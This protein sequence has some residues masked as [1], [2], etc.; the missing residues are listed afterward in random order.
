[1]AEVVA[2]AIG[3]DEAR[4]RLSARFAAWPPAGLRW[5]TARG[6]AVE[7]H[8]DGFAVRSLPRLLGSPLYEVAGR[9]RPEGGATIEVAP[10]ATAYMPLVVVNTLLLV[11]LFGTIALSGMRGNILGTIEGVGFGALLLITASLLVQV[12]IIAVLEWRQGPAERAA[13]LAVVRETLGP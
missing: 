6:H 4:A 12:G 11:L 3:R 7:Q 8:D 5:S 10:I 2:T 9:W 13:L 1:M